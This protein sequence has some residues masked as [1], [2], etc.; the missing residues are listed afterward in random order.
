[1]VFNCV[2]DHIVDG[3]AYP[4]MARWK[5]TPLSAQWREFGKH[6]P[7]T[8]PVELYEHCNRHQHPYNLYSL[9]QT[10]PD[11]SYYAVGLGFF[12]F[13]I[14][15]FDLMSQTIHQLLKNKKLKVLFYYH[16]GDN[17]YS[18]KQRLDT[19][20][21]QHQLPSDCYCFVSGNTEADKIS[22]FVYF[23]DHE[24]LYWAR[25]FKERGALIHT[26]PRPYKFTVLNRTHK[27]WRATVMTDLWLNGIL[28]HSQWS[29]QPAVVGDDNFDNNPIELDSI[30]DLRNNLEKFL[31]ICPHYCDS[32]NSDQHNDHSRVPLTHYTNSY[33][34]IILETHYDSDSSGGAFITEKTFKALKHGH[35]FVVVGCPGTLNTLRQLGYRTFDHAIDNS[36]DNETD[37]TK[38]WNMIRTVIKH[39]QN[40]KDMKSWFETCRDDLEHNQRLFA[41]SKLTRLNNLLTKLGNS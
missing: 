29:Y 25:G 10:F 37:N 23:P 32:L 1:M 34:S 7:Y 22:Q 21:G 4:S 36:Y 20:C 31:D 38:R 5:A 39:L 41:Q 18:I 30:P 40:N 12:S 35:P 14:D 11:N 24:L 16:E 6:W 19:L 8:V 13:E 3:R 27:W 2:A 15:Y 17:P 9:D 26:N 28:E 33:C